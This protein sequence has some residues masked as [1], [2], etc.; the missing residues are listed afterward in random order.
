MTEKQKTAF[1]RAL[2]D[3]VLSRHQS[4]LEA[5][6]EPVEFSEDY[7]KAVACLT[8]KTRRKTWKYVNTTAKRILIAAIIVML[9]A[10]TAFAAIPALREGLIRFFLHD[11]G[12]AYSFEFTE[13]DYASAPREIE[14]YYA[15][16][17]V[18]P[19]YT[20][21]DETYLPNV[22]E[23]VYTDESGNAFVYSQNVLWKADEGYD[24]PQGVG[25]IMSY[26]SENTTLDT[27]NIQGYEVKVLRTVNEQG[28]EDITLI[29]TDH[30]YY[31][32][33]LAVNLASSDI[34]AIIASIAPIET[35]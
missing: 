21:V 14:T 11:N 27:Q 8:K 31:Y 26:N 17:W 28:F 1:E 7:R 25:S 19:Q 18:P 13:E 33:V 6:R 3:A 35:P 32:D 20:L 2:T 9:L 5:D 34:E 22:G 24:Y 29:W 10:T 12:V 16:K 23:R 4:V 30:L 15:P